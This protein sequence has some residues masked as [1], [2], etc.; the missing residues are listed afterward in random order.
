MNTAERLLAAEKLSPR[1]DYA[2]TRVR[3]AYQCMI[4]ALNDEKTRGVSCCDTVEAVESIANVLDRYLPP[5]G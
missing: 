5:T 2:G 1:T 3:A 4:Q